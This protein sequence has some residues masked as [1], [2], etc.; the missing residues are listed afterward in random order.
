[1]K[2]LHNALT[3]NSLLLGL[4]AS[5]LA[6]ILRAALDVAVARGAL[7]AE[8]RDE[9]V[10]AL[11]MRE[12]RASTA[13]GHAVAVP[14]LYLDTLREPVIVFVQLA[15]PLNLGAPDGVPT[16]FLFVLLGPPGQAAEHLDTLMN[17]A[18]LMADEEFRYEAGEARTRDDLLEALE[19][20]LRRTRPP[21]MPA[22][23]KVPEGLRYTGRLAGGLLQD[24]RRRAAHYLDDFRAGLHPKSLSS[25]LFLFFACLAPAVTFGGF[26]AL[27]TGGQIGAVEMLVATAFCGVVFALLSGQ[28]LIIL[29]GT[30]PLLIFTAILYRLCSDL[31]VPFLPAYAWVGLWTALFT[32]ILALTD[33]SCLMRYFTRFTDE[34]FAALISII[35]I[36]ES[37]NAIVHVFIDHRVSHDTALLSLVLALGTFY[38]ALNLSRFRQSRYLLPRIREFLAD[39]GPTIALTLM[40]LVAVELHEVELRILAVPD[41]FST[42]SGRSWQINPFAAPVW[43]WAA[44][45]IPA[46]LGTVLVY[47]DQNITSRLV[48][49]PDNKLR[50]GPGYHLDLAVV[51]GLIGTCSLFGLPWLV[52][53]TVRS[54]NHLRSL[55]TTEEVVTP[56]GGRRERILHVRETRVT[57]LAIHLLIGLS[58]LALPLLKLIPMAVLYGLFLYMGVVSMRGNQFFERLSLWPMDPSLYP[59]THYIRK[60]P[61]RTVHLFTSIQVLCLAVLWVVKAGPLGI[62]FP[63]LIALLVPVRFLVGGLIASPYLA[64]LDA[65]EE[66]EEEATQWH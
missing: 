47:L 3:E 11:L 26:M 6:D 53:A 46:L 43:V 42:T 12:R 5:E 30:G 27:E 65:E 60:V 45:I 34:I 17:I 62:L 19:R 25:T 15:H 29:G 59:P 18:R 33:A 39:F 58:L 56:E 16:R 50:K 52:A 22:E 41:S 13:I 49:N 2:L 55:A 21:G 8:R 44:A 37:V 20:F 61:L 14:H 1:M 54:L 31:G 9:V 23:Q 64:A 24:V 66:P 38:I 35:F 63:L 10:E 36:Y 40:T 57:G 7:E 51:G 48:N 4:E 32:L 28:P